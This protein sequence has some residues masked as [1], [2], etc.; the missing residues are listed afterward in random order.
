MVPKLSLAFFS[1]VTNSRD[2]NNTKQNKNLSSWGL[3]NST[4]IYHIMKC[5]YNENCEHNVWWFCS[6][7]YSNDCDEQEYSLTL[8]VLHLNCT[9]ASLPYLYIPDSF[10]FLSRNRSL[11][12]L[13]PILWTNTFRSSLLMACCHL[14]TD[15]NIRPVH[16]RTSN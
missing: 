7:V 15:L 13:E 14:K 9:F 2:E 6:S 4:L 12:T 1:L 3:H 16:T 8:T 10:A 11:L 5:E